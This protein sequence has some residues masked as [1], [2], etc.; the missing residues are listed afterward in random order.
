MKRITLLAA[1]LLLAACRAVPATPLPTTAPTAAVV[2]TAAAP[3]LVPPTADPGQTTAMPNTTPALAPS[4]L[5]PITPA[6]PSSGPAPLFDVD[7]QDRAPYAAGLVNA[8][9]DDVP[10]APVYHL[11][12]TIADDMTTI[13]GRQTVTYTNQE[14]TPLREIVFHLHANVLD[15]AI[16]V[17]DLTVDGVAA[18]TAISGASRSILTVALPAPLPPGERVTIDLRFRTEVATEIGRNF[19]VLSFYEGILALAHFYPMLSV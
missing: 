10:G 19:G 1:L 3:T 16:A 4:P 17:S 8:A 18:R 5:P 15:S 12:I 2:A 11:D 6:P 7:P 9:A 13:D 14:N